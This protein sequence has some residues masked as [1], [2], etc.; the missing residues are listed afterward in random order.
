MCQVVAKC[1][2]TSNSPTGEK[3]HPPN[4][5]GVECLQ[6]CADNVDCQYVVWMHGPTD[7]SW[8]SWD[9]PWKNTEENW[10]TYGKDPDGKANCKM[11]NQYTPTTVEMK[12]SIECNDDT[13]RHAVKTDTMINWNPEIG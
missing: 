2:V 6:R 11:H 12:W 8:C 13:Y 9:P 7:G 3:R 10:Y 4:T 5:H 1:V